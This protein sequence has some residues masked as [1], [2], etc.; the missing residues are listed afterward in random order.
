M[1]KLIEKHQQKNGRGR[2]VIQLSPRAYIQSQ[3]NFIPGMNT[4]SNISVQQTNQQ[5]RQQEKV[6]KDTKAGNKRIA[7]KHAHRAIQER[8][9]RRRTLEKGITNAG[10]SRILNREV[11]RIVGAKPF[12]LEHPFAVKTSLLERGSV[13]PAEYQIKGNTLNIFK[14]EN[15]PGTQ[16]S[17]PYELSLDM[18][19]DFNRINK[20]LVYPLFNVE[21]TK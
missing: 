5:A 16:Y 11:G 3:L 18:P 7:Y 12:T 17:T 20:N 2:G 1:R 8:D 4:T 13:N 14:N 9:Q 21:R 10:K 19:F 15:V 6:D